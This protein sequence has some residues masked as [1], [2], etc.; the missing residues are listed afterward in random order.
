MGKAK[1]T[2]NKTPTNKTPA[3]RSP[4]TGP[5][6]RPANFLAANL[7][8][9]VNYMRRVGTLR[10]RRKYDL[11]LVSGWMIARLGAEAPMS[12]DQLAAR[13]GL[14]QSQ[15]SRT[16]SDLTLRGLIVRGVNP[17]FY[18][19][20]DLTLSAEG[21]GIYRDIVA[22][23]P[24]YERK[25][26]KGLTPAEIEM[27]ATVLPRLIANAQSTLDEESRLIGGKAE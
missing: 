17:D 13:A 21:A 20:A 26:T 4:R 14:A 1:T 10:F 24:D 3:K 15:V 6:R 22:D 7:I 23:A 11:P 12:I 25:L 5:T 2:T 9:L 19:E 27:L 18:R 16:I 8:A